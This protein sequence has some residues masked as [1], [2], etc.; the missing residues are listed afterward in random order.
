MRV[1]WK[2]SAACTPCVLTSSCASAQLPRPNRN[3]QQPA[4]VPRQLTPDF[5]SVCNPPT[6]PYLAR[7]AA[8]GSSKV[9]CVDKS[10]YYEL[11]CDAHVLTCPSPCIAG[12]KMQGTL[13]S[14]EV[15]QILVS[16]GGRGGVR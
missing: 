13:T 7:P 12:Q 11:V 6:P 9:L 16:G 15:Q 10:V 2:T 1:G 4:A 3:R 14:N 8:C 5:Y